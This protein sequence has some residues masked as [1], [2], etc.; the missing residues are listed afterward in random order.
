MKRLDFLAFFDKFGV[1]VLPCRAMP[2][3]WFESVGTAGPRV[4]QWLW[5]SPLRKSPCTALCCAAYDSTVKE[6]AT[7]FA[8][9]AFEKNIT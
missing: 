9:I 6:R 8:V 7:L 5:R 3:L 1:T 4:A 2:C